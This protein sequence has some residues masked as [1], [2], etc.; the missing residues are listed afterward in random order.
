MTDETCDNSF[1]V[2]LLIRSL[3]P[4]LRLSYLYFNRSEVTIYVIDRPTTGVSHRI[5]ATELFAF[6]SQAS[7]KP[8]LS[9]LGVE[10]VVPKA[11]PTAEQLKF[12][13]QHPPAG[14]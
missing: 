11:A 5:S 4:N 9:A 1:C 13:L 2:C 10:A 7:L 12:Y 14:L 6:L 8:Q 3:G